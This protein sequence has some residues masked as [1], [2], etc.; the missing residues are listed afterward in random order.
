[1]IGFVSERFEN[2]VGEVE[3][4]VKLV[5][6]R[7]RGH[8]SN[9]PTLLKF[10]PRTDCTGIQS[11]SICSFLTTE[12]CIMC[13]YVGKLPVAWKKCTLALYQINR[14]FNEPKKLLENIVGKG[15]NAGYHVLYPSQ[16]KFQSFS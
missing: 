16:I 5:L 4:S 6:Q 7:V 10:F 12:H 15:E 14:N 9:R 11:D 1:M 3:M 2:I 13:T 8:C